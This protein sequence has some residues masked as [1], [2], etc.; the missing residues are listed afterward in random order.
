MLCLFDL[1]YNNDG[2]ILISESS[3]ETNH[4]RIDSI[5]NGMIA[6]INSVTVVVA[7]R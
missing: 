5:K 3:L 1:V 2:Y 4:E 6:K 7:A